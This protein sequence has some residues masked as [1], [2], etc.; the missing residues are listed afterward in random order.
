MRVCW[1]G[2]WLSFVAGGG[3]FL[4]TLKYFGKR[5]PRLKWLRPLGPISAC[6]IAITAVVA[7]QL[8]DKGIRI[9]GSIPRGDFSLTFPRHTC[10]SSNMGSRLEELPVA[11]CKRAACAVGGSSR[12]MTFSSNKAQSLG[13]A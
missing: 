8:Q 13:C 1:C 10:T 5:S 7:G 2:I 12:A 4:L 3:R 9:V 6:G 11:L